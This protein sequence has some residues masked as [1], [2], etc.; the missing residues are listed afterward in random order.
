MLNN[1]V[2]YK[3]D[4]GNTFK[5]LIS[6]IIEIFENIGMILLT[7]IAMFLIGNLIVR[8]LSDCFVTELI[9]K[10]LTTITVIT[11][12]FFIILIFF[13]KKVILTD[14]KILVYRF[15][16]PLQITF[17]DIRGLNDRIAYS[18]IIFCQKHTDEIYFGSR[19]PFFCVNND[20][21]V[22]IRTNH[23]TYLLPIKDY[24]NFICEVN[25]RIYENTCGNNTADDGSFR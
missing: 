21:L 22:E 3:F 11:D 12:V 4:F 8:E 13:P 23:K 14:D 7:W 5:F 19:K 20:S 17:W 16:F 25:K 18:Q 15:C 10:F 6:Y 24:E 1:Y 9:L 2:K